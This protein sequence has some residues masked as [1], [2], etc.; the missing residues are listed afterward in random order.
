MFLLFTYHYAYEKEGEYFCKGGV[1][2]VESEQEATAMVDGY[3]A[4]NVPSDARLLSRKMHLVPEE[5]T[6]VFITLALAGR[7]HAVA[8]SF[9]TQGHLWVNTLE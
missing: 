9:M 7:T 5:E 4:V 8:R 6:V 3:V 1:A 2:L